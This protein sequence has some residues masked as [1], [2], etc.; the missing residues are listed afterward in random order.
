MGTV[1][2]MDVA[3]FPDRNSRPK[4][5]DTQDALEVLIRDLRITIDAH[6]AYCNAAIKY[7]GEFACFE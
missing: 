6:V 2:A 1:R 3:R 5:A 4:H 7:F